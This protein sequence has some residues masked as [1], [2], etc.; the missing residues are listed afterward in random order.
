M[1]APLSVL[2]VE[3][4]E[5]DAILIVHELRRHGYDVTSVRVDTAQAM[6]AAL[7]R[8]DWDAILSD[9]S[10]PGFT[11]LDALK[12]TQDTGKDIPF[13]IISGTIDEEAAVTAMK[14]GAH[15]FFSKDKL[16]RLVPALDR[17]LR[18]AD[19]RHRRRLAEEALRNSEERFRLLLESAP[20]A[21]IFVDD[22]AR[23]LLVNAHTEAIFGYPRSELIGQSIDILLPE[24]FRDI[25]RTHRADYMTAPSARLMGVGR[26]LWG[27]RKDGSEFPIEVGLN[28]VE[29]SQGVIVAC[30]IADIS[31][32][33]EIEEQLR[34]QAQ[35]LAHVS[36]AVISTDMDGIIQSWNPGAEA[37][38]GWKADEV[39]GQSVIDFLQTEYLEG[40]EQDALI[41][42]AEQGRWRD[43]VIQRRKDGARINIFSSV[44]FITDASG[45][46]I[47]MVAVNRDI[48][49][50]KRA[51]EELRQSQKRFA[52]AF[53]DGP[54][55]IAITTVEGVFLDVNESFLQLS[56]YQRNEVIGH[57]IQELD[58]WVDPVAS[59]NILR[60]IIEGQTIR[61]QELNVRIK[62]GEVRIGLCSFA[63]ID[64]PGE[65]CV[66]T[67]FQDITERTRAEDELRES[68]TRFAAIFNRSPV[69]TAIFRVH[70]LH[71]VNVNDAFI[72]LLGYD[73]D[74][75]IGRTTLEIG[76]WVNPEKR[77]ESVEVISQAGGVRSLEVQFKTKSGDARYLLASAELIDLG[78][79]PHMVSMYY[80]ITEQKRMQQELLEAERLRVAFEKERELVELKERFISVASHDLRTPLAVIV[81]ST[82]I[83][84]RSRIA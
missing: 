47:G 78:A 71:I 80:D 76:V 18:E 55:G 17:E 53:Q 27:R 29:T 48:T 2:I 3:D 9:Y 37:I 69:P 46:N 63:A 44:S 36:E 72:E 1:D 41:Q 84:Q 74:E 65:V 73:R 56:S 49:L 43:E 61:D 42:L 24:R 70:D 77:A 15:D 34:Y 60:A 67:M 32:R 81:S 54:L 82:D 21:L 66:L 8:Q 68:E 62:S 20:D 38:Y 31:A 12:L 5:D 79:E 11:A 16:T 25:H 13:I 22:R 30:T 50:R 45:Q 10:M 26:E 19:D 58:L 52:K 75:L 51:E 23:M 40:S 4:L 64:L 28:T 7:D 6:S 57:T 33:R 39:V 35:L 83:L 59:D 14:A